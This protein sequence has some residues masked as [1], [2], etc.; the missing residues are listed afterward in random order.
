MLDRLL[1]SLRK[2]ITITAAPETFRFASAMREV[3]ID[4]ALRVAP[5]GRI[6]GFGESGVTSDGQVQVMRLFTAGGAEVD[7]R[8]M[9]ALCRRGLALTLGPL[10]MRP[11]VLV[12]GAKRVPVRPEVFAR[13]LREAGAATVE[14]T[15]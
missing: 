9:V 7:E 8:A 1:A 5:D 15:D 6:L 11:R 2:T 4:T 12:R 14:F 10:G 13:A 3:S